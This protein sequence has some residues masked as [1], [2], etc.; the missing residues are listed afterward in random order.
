MTTQTVTLTET[1][2]PS[3]SKGRGWAR[4]GGHDAGQYATPKGREITITGP[5]DLVIGC[6]LR[7][8]KSGRIEKVRETY[9]LVPAEGQ[10]VDL[11]VGHPQSYDITVHG[12]V[13]A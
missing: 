2:T 6:D 1:G 12:A 10:S 11:W 8:G 9:Q 5:F 13:Q 7:R 3:R 4:I